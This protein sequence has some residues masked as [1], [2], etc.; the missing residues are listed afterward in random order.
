MKEAK[1]ITTLFLDI[2]GVL[3]T[4]GRSHESRPIKQIIINKKFNHGK[5]IFRHNEGSVIGRNAS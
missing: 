4:N 1:N 3:L 5:S 2:G